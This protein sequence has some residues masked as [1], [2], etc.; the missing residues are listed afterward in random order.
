MGKKTDEEI[1]AY[2]KR[3]ASEILEVEV[4]FDALISKVISADPDRIGLTSKRSKS[5]PTNKP[6]VKPKGKH[7]GNRPEQ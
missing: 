3:H 1:V 6:S 5:Q 2:L 4:D 7:S